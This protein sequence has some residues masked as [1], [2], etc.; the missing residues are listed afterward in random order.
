MAGSGTKNSKWNGGMHISSKGYKRIS[1]RTG[2]NK[3]YHR[4]LIEKLLENP[5][6]LDYVFPSPKGVIPEGMEIHHVDHRGYH[7]CYGN[8]Q[9]LDY[10][11]HRFC[12][13]EYRKWISENYKEWCKYWREDGRYE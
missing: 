13:R 12:E 4:Y 6:A 3:Y 10:R 7:N 1:T 2:R 5:I 8:L 9:L 11:I